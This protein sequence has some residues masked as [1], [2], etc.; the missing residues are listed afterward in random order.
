MGLDE[1][2]RSLFLIGPDKG[3][4]FALLWATSLQNT[5]FG[6][7]TLFLFCLI[8]SKPPIYVIVL[9]LRESTSLIISFLNYLA[10]F[11]LSGSSVWYLNFG[12]CAPNIMFPLLKFYEEYLK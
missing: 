7:L 9:F 6:R 8:N 3:P 1:F 11:P 12:Y 5:V 4:P 10:T 2:F